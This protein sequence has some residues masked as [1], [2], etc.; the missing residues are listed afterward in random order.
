MTRYDRRPRR[1]WDEPRRSPAS[2]IGSLRLL[3]FL[4]ILASS[5]LLLNRGK[6]EPPATTTPRVA[7]D[8]AIAAPVRTVIGS[9]T[10]TTAPSQE[11]TQ[12]LRDG[13]VVDLALLDRDA[14]QTLI[15][16]GTCSDAAVFASRGRTQYVACDVNA[17]GSSRELASTV[18]TRLASFEGRDALIGAGLDVPQTGDPTTPASTPPGASTP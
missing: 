3:G 4:V 18:R 12:R 1:D 7:V 8:A 15:D 11:L 6:D 14:A 17:Q 10:L 2:Q 16:A 9:A 13:L 5:F